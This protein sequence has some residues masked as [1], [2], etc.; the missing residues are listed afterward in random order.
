MEASRTGQP[1]CPRPIRGTPALDRG[2]RPGPARGGRPGS[3]IANMHC[4]LQ[5]NVF[6]L[7]L[8]PMRARPGTLISAESWEITTSCSLQTI[9]DRKGRDILARSSCEP[10]RQATRDENCRA[11]SSSRKLLFPER[12]CHPLRQ[13][14]IRGLQEQRREAPQNIPPLLAPA[15]SSH[16]RRHRI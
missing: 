3:H 5:A 1:P 4:V 13:Q 2:S 7:F 15:G 14:T 8:G 16:Q 6:V 12:E 9:T 10:A 11:S